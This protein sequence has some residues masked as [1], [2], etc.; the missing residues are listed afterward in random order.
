[1]RPQ[2]FTKYPRQLQTLGGVKRGKMKRRVGIPS[3]PAS[4]E[5][6][7]PRKSDQT[8]VVLVETMLPLALLER[9]VTSTEI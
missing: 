5:I 3:G 2:T 8:T 7:P 9:G 4:R 1:M 6:K